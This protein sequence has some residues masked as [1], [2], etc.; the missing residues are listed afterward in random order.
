MVVG[1]HVA[2]EHP[3]QGSIQTRPMRSPATKSGAIDRLAVK[4]VN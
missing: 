4:K 2:A 3:S 1:R